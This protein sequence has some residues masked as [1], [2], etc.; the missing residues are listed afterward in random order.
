MMKAL[1]PSCSGVEVKHAAI[2]Y[3]HHFKDMRM[4][5]DEYCG[6]VGVQ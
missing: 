2:F 4:A 5:T 1:D 3:L 6:F